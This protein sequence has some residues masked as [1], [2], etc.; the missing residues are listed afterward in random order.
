MFSSSPP[1]RSQPDYAGN[2]L[3]VATV[4]LGLA[5]VILALAT[6]GCADLQTVYVEAD[7][8]TFEAVA[9]EYRAYVEADE[10]LDD[11]QKERREKTLEAWQR[12]IEEASK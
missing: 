3:K 11:R 6:S 1:T 7:R 2:C 5:V 8:L 4:I 10:G 9:P 12:R